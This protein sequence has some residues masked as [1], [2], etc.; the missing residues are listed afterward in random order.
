MKAESEPP[1]PVSIDSERLEASLFAKLFSTTPRRISVGRYR[2]LNEVGVGGMGQV[3]SAYDD[4]L[5]R[6][7]AVKVV[8]GSYTSERAGTRLRR[9]AQALGRL[10]HPNIVAVH[11]IGARTRST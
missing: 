4:E 1:T 11:E 2:I 8:R 3:F 10:T 6:K 5:D 7:V 9:E